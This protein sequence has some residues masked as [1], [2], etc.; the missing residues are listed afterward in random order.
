MQAFRT[1]GLPCPWAPLQSVTTAASRR[2]RLCLALTSHRSGRKRKTRSGCPTTS[3]MEFGS[4][5]RMNPGDRCVGLPPRHHPL[6]E[7][8]TPSAVLARPGLVALFRATSTHRI[9]AFRAFSS[10]PAVTP[11]DALCSLAVS[12]S[13]DFARASSSSTVAPTDGCSHATSTLRTAS[14]LSVRAT[15][16]VNLSISSS[17]GPPK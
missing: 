8:L 2:A 4:F 14:A 11:L 17:L 10:R 7:F 13:S 3:P 16:T 5:R 6:S 1:F 9:S 15:P 12:A